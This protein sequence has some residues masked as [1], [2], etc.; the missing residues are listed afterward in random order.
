MAAIEW[1]DGIAPKS[2][3][4]SIVYNNRIFQSSFTN[5]Q[6]VVGSTGDYWQAT[7]NFDVLDTAKQRALT[8]FF[9]R[10]KGMHGT[11][12]VPTFLR[13]RTDNIGSPVIS[14]ALT[15]ATSMVISGV[16]P[17]TQVFNAGDYIT[18]G[19]EL[20]E[21][22]DNATSNVSGQVVVNVNKRI[23][24]TLSAGTAVEYKN[25]YCVMRLTSDSL[26][27]N[28]LDGLFAGSNVTFMEAI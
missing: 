13:Y 2:M 7:M 5:H 9:G 16:L 17:S 21:I 6:Q 20:F 14:S 3:D 10:L 26:G 8:A 18:T 23:R 1:V 27:L 4:F 12:K 15:Q 19:D 28:G 24:N 11:V 25:P 22:T